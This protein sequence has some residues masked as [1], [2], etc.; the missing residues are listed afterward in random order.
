MEKI[1]VAVF[2]TVLFTIFT[3]KEEECELSGKSAGAP[4]SFTSEKAYE[5]KD[6]FGPF[7]TP[8]LEFINTPIKFVRGTY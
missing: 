4:E 3:P 6:I 7:S 1:F 8:D 5:K 2:T